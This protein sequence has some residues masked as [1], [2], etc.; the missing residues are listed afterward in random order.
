MSA[1]KEAVPTQA[2]T[3]A[4]KL[5]ATEDTRAYN[6]VNKQMLGAVVSNAD[7]LGKNAGDCDCETMLVGEAKFF[8]DGSLFVHF[9][10][11]ELFDSDS[12]D[13]VFDSEDTFKSW[14]QEL[15]DVNPDCPDTVSFERKTK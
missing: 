1:T 5:N 15:Q 2:E 9:Y 6:R 14:L 12:D 3:W 7:V 4:D 10:N 13:I 11:S 8:G